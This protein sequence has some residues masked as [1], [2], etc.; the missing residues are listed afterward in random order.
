[1]RNA[2]CGTTSGPNDPPTARAVPKSYTRNLQSHRR[3]LLIANPTAGGGQ[4]KRLAEEIHKRLVHAGAHCSIEVTAAPGHA[5]TIARTALQRAGDD[6][7]KRLCVVPCGGDG[8]TQE[9]VNA[10][11]NRPDAGGVL[12]LAPC[13][14]CNDFASTFGIRPDPNQIVDLLLA[15]QTRRVDVGRINDRYF[16]TIAA[17]GFDAAV[18][19]YVNDTRLPFAGTLAYVFGTLRVLLTFKPVTVRLKYDDSS[20]EGQLFLAASAN[21]TSYGGRMRIAPNADITDGLLEVCLVSKLS[22]TGG[23][24]LLQSV[25]RGRHTELTGVRFVRTPSL[26]IETAERQEVWADGEYVTDTPVK[27]EIVPRALEIVSPESPIH[28]D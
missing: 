19:R 1:M 24:N 14:R 28:C 13:G 26:E 22:R 11:L 7:S 3:F 21:T 27:I 9:V 23:L 25:L 2:E 17:M 10:L 20:F 8:T 6:R 16:C 15:N 4:G 12:G 18:S 5:E